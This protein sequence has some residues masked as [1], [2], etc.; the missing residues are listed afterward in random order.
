MFWVSHKATAKV[1]FYF[2][3]YPLKPQHPAAVQI[4]QLELLES[5]FRYL[6]VERIRLR[7]GHG[8]LEVDRAGVHS[9]REYFRRLFFGKD[10]PQAGGHG[11]AVIPTNN[12][13]LF[14]KLADILGV[15]DALPLAEHAFGHNKRGVLLPFL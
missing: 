10:D 1:A 9:I 15:V 11:L 8:Q 2:L 13:I 5:H 14:L 4:D 6:E 3:L 12:R 7:A